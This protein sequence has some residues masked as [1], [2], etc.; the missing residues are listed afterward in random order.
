MA[1]SGK[2]DADF[3]SFYD[4]CRKATVELKGFDT[5]TKTVEASLNRMVEEFS[6]KEIQAE[7]ALMVEAIARVGGVSKLTE[8]E[9][10]RVAAVASEAAAKLRATG[11]AVPA[12]LGKIAGYATQA[13]TATES[14]TASVSQFDNIF[15]AAGINIGPVT[16]GI[17]EIAATAGK[18]ASE[19]GA[20]GTA[21]LVL[22]A[23]YAGWQVGRAVADFF[24]LDETIGN[25]TAAMLGF[26]DV[27]AESAAAKADT[28]ARAS[29]IA[30]FEVETMSTAML[31]LTGE[32]QRAQAA[33]DTSERRLKNWHAELANARGGTDA[34]TKDLKSQVFTVQELAKK[35]DVSVEAIQ[36]YT[37]EQEAAKDATE[38]S[39][40]KIAEANARQVRD[41]QTVID[42]QKPFKEAMVELSLTG[43]GWVGTLDTIDGAVVEAVKYYLQAG[44]SQKALADAYRLT[45]AQ[46]KAVAATAAATDAA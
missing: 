34:L 39:Q 28:L 35:Y 13:K 23:G 31:V 26:G 37:R 8:T 43:K 29:K 11:E 7:A 22:G 18:S 36:N 16:K 2:L 12:G 6:G 38:K 33:L 46:V 19:I 32:T 5:E 1:L 24:K 40:A 45:D 14:L 4:A 3:A 44:V 15:S 41:L 9:L 27:A 20:L 25:A 17:S 10:Q 21:G 42:A 30:G